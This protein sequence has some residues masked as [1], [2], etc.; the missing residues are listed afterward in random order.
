MG[1]ENTSRISEN[2]P[3]VDCDL[4]GSKFGRLLILGRHMCIRLQS[5]H[6]ARLP[7]HHFLAQHG[8]ALLVIYRLHSLTFVPSQFDGADMC[9]SCSQHWTQISKHPAI[10]S[11]LAPDSCDPCFVSS[12]SA[13]PHSPQRVVTDIMVGD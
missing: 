1:F 10:L 5:L 3:T 7:F 13:F 8:P 9:R 2:E 4:D 6:R 11:I 12:S